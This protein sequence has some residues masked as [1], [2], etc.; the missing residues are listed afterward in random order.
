M[1]SLH[2]LL[3]MPDAGCFSGAGIPCWRGQGWILGHPFSTDSK[4]LSLVPHHLS[5][6]VP[7]PLALVTVFPL[8]VK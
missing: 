8:I 5:L 1:Q 6:L 4:N 7:R 3:L 2:V